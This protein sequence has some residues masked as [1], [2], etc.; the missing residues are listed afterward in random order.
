M[1]PLC[2]HAVRF[3]VELWDLWVMRSGFLW[4]ANQSLSCYIRWCAW[5]RGLEG[6][7]VRFF[8][9]GGTSYF[10]KVG[11]KGCNIHRVVS[12]DFRL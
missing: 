1:W 12:P 4:F 11:F 7:D 8:L 9:C 6:A 10:Y 2:M 5:S 3:L